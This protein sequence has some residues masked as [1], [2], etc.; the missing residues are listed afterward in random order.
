MSRGRRSKAL[1]ALPA[2]QR[3]LFPEIVP[4][5][6]YPGGYRLPKKSDAVS[7]LR[8]AFPGSTLDKPEEPKALR[9]DLGAVRGLNGCERP[10][11]L[12]GSERSVDGSTGEIH[13]ADVTA[14]AS[15][16]TRRA[17]VCEP[18]SRLYQHDARHL[19]VSGLTGGKGVGSEVAARPALFV[20]FTA[21]SFG[22]VHSAVPTGKGGATR[23]C[24][25]RRGGDICPHGV[26]LAC[27]A[28]HGKSDQIVGSAICPD[29]YDYEGAVLWNNAASA[30][31]RATRI[32]IDRQLA[33]L[34][35]VKVKD[36]AKHFK[37]QYVKV[38]E[39]QTR[40]LVHFHVTIRLDGPEESMP[41]LPEGAEDR[42][43]GALDD[44]GVP[45]VAPEGSTALRGSGTAAKAGPAGLVARKLLTDGDGPAA[46]LATA[47][48]LA[49]MGANVE[50]AAGDRVRWGT[51]LDVRPIVADD[52][53]SHDHAGDAEG[54]DTFID[55]EA[56][57]QRESEGLVG[58]RQVA[59]Y[60]SKY[61]TKGSDVEGKLDRIFHNENELALLNV[62]SHLAKMVR[63]SWALAR[64]FPDAR[65]DRW[66][67]QLGHRGH[68][69]TKS[70]GWSTTFAALRQA[71]RDHQEAKRLESLAK[72][73]DNARI[74]IEARWNFAGLGYRSPTEAWLA[75]IHRAEQRDRTRKVA[76]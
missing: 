12:V 36:K 51:Q 75:E 20:T 16:K 56:E 71:R 44:F 59:K 57:A 24:R 54:D 15:C 70:R 68:F 8:R 18:C 23:T 2:P 46:A 47:I 29:C 48:L 72:L 63:T 14:Y 60:V 73:N 74:A 25:P 64:R 69:L 10:I 34:Y 28:H 9:F 65:L 33:K 21:P 3:S 26:D 5:T 66:S 32:G 22:V 61:A 58:R 4:H 52:L 30:L 41:V 17:T 40:G 1:A 42:I 6:P 38:A 53:D 11:Q 31:W 13:T 35:G 55:E 62:N 39:F 50:N 7:R 43:A 27:W 76:S 19:V 67:H 37:T 49:A 45:E